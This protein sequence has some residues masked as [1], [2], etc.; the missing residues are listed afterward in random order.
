VAFKL[1]LTVHSLSYLCVTMLNSATLADA[2]LT[3]AVHFFVISSISFGD[4]YYET[5]VLPETR[6]CV[7][8]FI[9]TKC[10]VFCLVDE[11]C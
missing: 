11:C 8:V 6:S 5:G 3:H 4:V 9:L 2:V 7:F 10:F 1:G